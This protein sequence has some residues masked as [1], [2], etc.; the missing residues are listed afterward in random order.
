MS[1]VD[2]R[3][4]LPQPVVMPR[5]SRVDVPNPWQLLFKGLPQ[6]PLLGVPTALCAA[7]AGLLM[8]RR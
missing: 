5:L 1:F 2:L 7:A 6:I 4:V 3:I 8:S